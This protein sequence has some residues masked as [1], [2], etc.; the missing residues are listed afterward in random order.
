MQILYSKQ[1]QESLELQIHTQF[2]ILIHYFKIL[3][4]DFF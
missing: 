1:H 4:S 3:Y 2:I